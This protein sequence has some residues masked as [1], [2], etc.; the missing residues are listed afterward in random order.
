[1]RVQKSKIEGNFFVQRSFPPSPP[2]E[3]LMFIFC[4][5]SSLRKANRKCQLEVFGEGSGEEPFFN[6]AGRGAPQITSLES[7]LVLVHLL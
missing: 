7:E 6:P 2:Q 5:L 3:T 1:M 4:S